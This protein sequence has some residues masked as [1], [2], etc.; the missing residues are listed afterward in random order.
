MSI[1]SVNTAS[2]EIATIT[3][4]LDVT[5]SIYV[6]GQALTNTS[7]K[8]GTLAFNRG[9]SGEYSYYS[10]MEVNPP[11]ASFRFPTNPI[12][13]NQSV[14]RITMDVW[15]GVWI[16]GDSEYTGSFT[17]KYS[18][19]PNDTPDIWYNYTQKLFEIIN[20]GL[21]DTILLIKSVD[22][23]NTYKQFKIKGGTYYLN[24]YD[25]V[26]SAKVNW[27]DNFTTFLS[28]NWN[29]LP[30]ANKI[31]DPTMFTLSE[32]DVENENM[33]PEYYQ[34]RGS[35]GEPITTPTA[36][37]DL[38]VEQISSN[39]EWWAE[40]L[41]ANK[42]TPIASTV[43][44]D[45]CRFGSDETLNDLFSIDIQDAAPTKRRKVIHFVTSSKD[46]T[47]PSWAE[48]I[49][50]ICVGAGGGGGGGAS[51]FIHS[52]SIP[53]L[54]DYSQNK[55]DV[56][57]SPGNYTPGTNKN[58][59]HEFVTGGGGGAGG[60]V[61][62]ETLTGTVVKNNR[63]NSLTVTVGRP[64]T[65]GTGSSYFDDV[66]AAKPKTTYDYIENDMWRV[67]LNTDY[68]FKVDMASSN[69]SGLGLLPKSE[70]VVNK[71]LHFT[72][73]PALSSGITTISP[74]ENDHNG[75]SGGDTFVSLGTDI[76]VIAKGGNG[77]TGG[78]SIRDSYTPYHLMCRSLDHSP[79][80][81]MVPGGANKLSECKGS[82][83]RVGGPGGYG[84]T[85]PSPK[86]RWVKS[87]TPDNINEFYYDEYGEG[88]Y[89]ETLFGNKAIDVPWKSNNN[90]S[91]NYPNNNFPIGNTT[92]GTLPISSLYLKYNS[93]GYDVPTKPAPTGGGGGCGVSY[94][95]INQ[96]D[97]SIYNSLYPK[98]VAYLKNGAQVP[99][100]FFQRT[101]NLITGSVEL[102]LGGSNTL[103]EYLI[104]DTD[105]NGVLYQYELN[106]TGSHGGYGFY[107]IE[108][109]N[110]LSPNGVIYTNI[111]PQ[112]GVDFGYG[113]GGGAGRYVLDHTNKFRTDDENLYPTKGQDGADGGRGLAIIIFE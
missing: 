84:V 33:W 18:H 79:S 63:G 40:R 46:I 24:S 50:S 34:Y 49:T 20:K 55:N 29:D 78:I 67:L 17:S 39:H 74:I 6:N 19:N 3:N 83:I 87:I 92:R 91:S 2:F 7:T 95:G 104:N 73:F 59:G 85:M 15:N 106:S 30:S 11:F 1:F 16:T 36:Y 69:I 88:L 10:P 61:S 45:N 37:F 9:I 71:S 57:G 94:N 13:W 26:N 14:N 76:F 52:G 82:E 21:T 97:A 53:F 42:V 108:T 107:G 48:K 28:T 75:K 23:P 109:D 5:G 22:F 113:G 98:T 32:W 93:D 8:Y 101:A 112:S 25:G 102:G 31:T 103:T 77:G 44:P 54:E 105:E 56:N 99:D 62:I 68:L 81:A 96:K 70:N 100:D 90:Y 27:G 12:D 35:G 58:F 80:L 60:C 38:D 41:F 86:Q 47:I 89:E 64:G 4:F 66:V 43:E 51:G 65:G 111:Q 110:K 72:N